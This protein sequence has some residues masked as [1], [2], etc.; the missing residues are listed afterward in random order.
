MARLAQLAP[1][2]KVH[3]ASC[4]LEIAA[5]LRKHAKARLDSA[6]RGIEWEYRK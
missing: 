6:L 3:F 2:G 1:G 5:E 4:S